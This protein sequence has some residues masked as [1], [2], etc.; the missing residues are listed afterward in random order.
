MPSP[1]SDTRVNEVIWL[2]HKN[3]QTCG[4]CGK[5]IYK[6]NWVQLNRETGVRCGACAGYGDMWFLGAGDALLTRKATQL[7]SR[8]VTV[9]QWSNTRKRN[10][11][12]GIL[13]EK[14]AYRDALAYAIAAPRKLSREAAERLAH[15]EAHIDDDL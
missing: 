1:N 15:L 14:K 8:V 2:S 12:Q 13:V 7:S 4:D 3:D 6:G 10:E 5:E 9:V 11:R